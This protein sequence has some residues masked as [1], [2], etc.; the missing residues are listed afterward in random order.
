MNPVY[1]TAK[2]FQQSVELI[3]SSVEGERADAMFYDWLVNNIPTQNLTQNEV[4]SIRETIMSIKAD[5][6]SHNS[7]FKNMYKQITKRE[8]IV[9]DEMFIPPASFIEGIN[10]A[11]NGELNAVKKYRTIMEGLPSN[12]YRDKVFNILT[13]ELRHGSLYNHIYTTVLSAQ[14]KSK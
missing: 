13:D 5:E 14:G 1:P 9:K 7:M 11:L 3:Q 4:E 6:L 10:K 8:A 2:Q 12:Y